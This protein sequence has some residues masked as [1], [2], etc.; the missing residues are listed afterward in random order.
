MRSKFISHEEN[1]SKRTADEQRVNIYRERVGAG[2]NIAEIL[3]CEKVYS[4]QAKKKQLH[5]YKLSTPKTSV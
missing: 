4:K 2:Y 1:Y 5:I 3:Q